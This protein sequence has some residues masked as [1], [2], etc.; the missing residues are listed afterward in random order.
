MQ[1]NKLILLATLPSLS[2]ALSLQEMVTTSIDTN[3]LVK[4]QKETQRASRSRL[5][6]EYSA[7]LPNL[8]VFGNVGVEQADTPS[9]NQNG[10]LLNKYDSSIVL[11]ENIF[12]GFDTM[13][14]VDAKKA[15]L[16]SSKSSLEESANS[17]ALDAT[18]AYLNVLKTKELVD[19][20][21]DN[22]DV[23]EKILKKIKKQ[24]SVGAQRQSLYD[25]TLSRFEA[26][27]STLLQEEQNHLNAIIT[28]KR[29]SN[30]TIDPLTLEKINNEKI[31]YQSSEEM[32]KVAMKKNP[33]IKLNTFTIKEKK[34][35]YKRLAS[36]YYPA[37]DLQAEAKF[38]NNINAQQGENNSVAGLVVLSYNL[39]HGG[40]DMAKREENMHIMLEK[41]ERLADAK[42]LI[43]E[44]DM[45]AWN[46]FSYSKKQLVHLN[47]HIEAA[48][49][50]VHDYY[51]EYEVGRRSLVDLLNSQLEL[52]A[53]KNKTIVAF[54]AQQ[55][56]YYTILS[57]SGELLETFNIT[58][59][60]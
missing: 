12:K 7:Y 16:N 8:D 56:A 25:Q 43:T 3:P 37:V 11:K 47:K 21:Q 26:A 59:E 14:G 2:F 57:Y 54:Y 18:Q 58:L 42:R 60:K 55:E 31:P 1:I 45:I 22:V 5:R 32:L 41:Q 9:N 10:D 29:I 23:H 15:A 53:A 38:R 30:L 6:Q 33:T 17:I 51:K 39:Y 40:A 13:N 28:F 19:I 35:N 20:A 52:N 24:V 50:T 4:I 27:K 44:K 34:Y 36:K 48:K 46:T 49:K